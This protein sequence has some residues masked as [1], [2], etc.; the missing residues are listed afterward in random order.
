[1]RRT[2]VMIIDQRSC[3]MP[4]VDRR[5][6]AARG[7]RSIVIRFEL[8][9][10]TRSCRILLAVSL[11]VA[12]SL[13]ASKSFAAEAGWTRDDAAH[14]LRRAAFGGTPTQIDQIHALG[15]DGAVE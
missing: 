14:L 1:M 12:F 2:R 8:R 11:W 6:R 9:M 5:V 3:H 15:R 7:V 13:A 10:Q 4:R